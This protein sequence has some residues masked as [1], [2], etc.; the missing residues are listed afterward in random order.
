MSRRKAAEETEEP[1]P[2][3]SRTA[4]GCVLLGLAVIAV[5]A[6]YAVSETALVLVG[7][8]IGAAALWRAARSVPSAANPAPPPPPEGAGK[9][10]P[11]F[12]VVED[13][14]GHCTINWQKER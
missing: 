5:A 2:E 8:A 7:W 14:P 13:K 11:Q 9:A 10:K 3:A 4:G 1:T 6:L 12:S